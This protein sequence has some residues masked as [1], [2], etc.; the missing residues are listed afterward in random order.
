MHRERVRRL[1]ILL[2]A[3]CV[4][5]CSDASAPPLPP[6]R[7]VNVTPDFVASFA[8][9]NDSH[10]FAVEVTDTLGN[11]LTGTV[12]WEIAPVS[13]A[14]TVAAGV[15]TI[16]S[17]A[18]ARD[19]RLRATVDGVSDT[20][21]VRVLPRP[22]GKLVFS[23]S[24]NNVGE[25]FVKDFASP[26]D[27]TSIASG[28]GTIAGIAVDQASGRVFFSLGSLPNA[29]IWRVEIDGSGL[30]NVTNDASL[31]NQGPA[32]N[33]VTHD[34]YF[35]RRGLTGTATQIFRMTQGGTGLTEVTTGTQSKLQPAVSADGSRLAW[36]EFYP[37]F[38]LEI[39][40]AMIDGANPVRMTDRTGF[41][42]G[43]HWLTNTSVAWGGAS[44]TQPDVFLADAPSGSNARN[45]TNAAGRS[46]LPSAGCSA[47]TLTILRTAASGTA[48]YQLDV[49]TGLA[50]K[51]S[52]PLV[53]AIT[54]ARRLC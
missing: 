44:T 45:L 52:L 22:G 13:A 14:V 32:I 54:F 21:I 2:L 43:P 37:G 26:G 9:L 23:T 38:N 5:G 28:A 4:H 25:V 36:G 15:V 31:S 16:T 35:S 18:Q 51:Y 46:T 48:A 1:F 34:V 50:V 3:F 24:A 53:R 49:L 39:V 27:A 33:P 12:A 30:A 42:V 10:T 29:D 19:Y 20:A 8:S 6:N 41:D 47:N 11:P 17:A 40:T 7:V